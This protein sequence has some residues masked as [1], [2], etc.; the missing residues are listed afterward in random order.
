IGNSFVAKAEPDG[1]TLLVGNTSMVLNPLLYNALPYDQANLE[2]L[3]MVVQF[4]LV[5]VANND[6]P[7]NNAR[8]FVDYTKEQK[9]KVNF[10]SAGLG[11]STHLAG[12]LFKIKTGADMT[13][14]PYNGSAL[15][16]TAVV[17]GDVHTFFDTTVT[18]LPLVQSKKLKAIAIA[19]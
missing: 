12:E 14:I 19:S 6:V 13:H 17:G 4:P 7:V 2:P 11:N 9:G 15:G 3:A 1:Y 16:L 10:A 5:M 8:E 18:A